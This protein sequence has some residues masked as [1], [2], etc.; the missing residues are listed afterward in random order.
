MA[1]TIIPHRAILEFN[2]DGTFKDC[3]LQYRIQ[4]A[5]GNVDPKFYSISAAS[6]IS[7]PI[8]NGILTAIK[9]FVTNQENP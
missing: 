7:R 3:I 4:D 5:T 2:V 9:N 8:M 1:R 6:Q